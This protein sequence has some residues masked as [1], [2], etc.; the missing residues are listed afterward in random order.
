MEV[1]A[2]REHPKKPNNM[3]KYW[4]WQKL[5]TVHDNITILYIHGHAG[6]YRIIIITNGTFRYV[7]YAGLILLFRFFSFFIPSVFFY[8]V[9]FFFSTRN[10]TYRIIETVELK[11]WAIKVDFFFC[12][13]FSSFRILT[14]H[15]DFPVPGSYYYTTRRKGQP[16]SMRVSMRPNHV[17]SPRKRANSRSN[18]SWFARDYIINHL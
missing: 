10:Y 2:W 1:S 5:D 4:V 17:F 15:L 18:L 8:F 6:L 16:I 12:F 9:F 14:G 3:R 13:V 11:S 7:L